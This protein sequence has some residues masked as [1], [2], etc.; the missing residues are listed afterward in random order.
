[1]RSDG[2]LVESVTD[3]RFHDAR[4]FAGRNRSGRWVL[5]LAGIRRDRGI[6]TTIPAK[7]G[8]CAGYLRDRDFTASRPGHTWVMDFTIAA[9][10]PGGCMWRSS[11]TC[12]RDASLAGMHRPA[13]TW[14]LVM[15]AL[16]MSL[17]ERGRRG[18]SIQPQQLRAHSDVHRNMFRWRT[19]ENS[20]WMASHP[21]LGPS[22]THT[23]VR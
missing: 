19:P 20:P 4:R 16:R 5:G 9:R 1:M 21:R 13:N 23:V 2:Y 10:R 15:I 11:S 22:V 17:C 6:R 3:P 12:S 8:I 14:R 18:P 7:D